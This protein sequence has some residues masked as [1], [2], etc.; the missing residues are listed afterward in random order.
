MNAGTILIWAFIIIIVAGF[1]AGICKAL[2]NKEQPSND[3][4]LHNAERDDNKYTETILDYTI[5]HSSG[6]SNFHIKG[7]QASNVT[8]AGGNILPINTRNWRQ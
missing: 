3:K 7:N 8:S 4:K 5:A 6:G 1:V 2:F